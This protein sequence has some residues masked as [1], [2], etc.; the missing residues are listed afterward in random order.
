MV[1]RRQAVFRQTPLRSMRSRR[2]MR[3]R[4]EQRFVVWVWRKEVLSNGSSG[5]S[6]SSADMTLTRRV[7]RRRSLRVVVDGDRPETT[8]WNT[9][10][11]EVRIG[12][13]KGSV[14]HV[15]RCFR[16]MVTSLLRDRDRLGV[17]HNAAATRY[18]PTWLR[19]RYE[20]MVMISSSNCTEGKVFDLLEVDLPSLANSRCFFAKV[21][22][23]GLT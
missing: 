2:Y 10:P 20:V 11:I 4:V 3:I 8:D 18:L 23:R 17:F 5:R 14:C 1:G 9:G 22:G 16:W 19:C 12:R 6:R 15:R 21:P 7:Q 13:W